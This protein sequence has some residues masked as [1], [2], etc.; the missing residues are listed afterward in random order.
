MNGK[1]SPQRR[2]PGL[3]W[4]SIVVE[5]RPARYGVGGL[6]PCVLFLHGWGIGGRP[7]ARPLEQLVRR[8]IR[9][10]T[11]ALPGFGGTAGLP[12][13]HRTLAGYAR[14]IGHF[15]DAVGLPLPVTVVGH[16]FGGGVAIKAAHD[17]PELAERLV[18]VNSI[19]GSAWT[20]G[21]G[22]VRALRERPLWD[23][24]LHLQADLLPRRQVTRVL[25]VILREAVPNMLRHPAGVWEAAHLARAA[26]LAR[27]LTALAERRLPIFVVWS[28]RD[29]VIPEST[30]MSLRTALGDPHAIT[31]PGGH[32]WL[33]YDPHAFG[34]LITNVI[35][36]PVIGPDS[37]IDR[38][39]AAN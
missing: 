38:P 22:A 39:T 2:F 32:T 11:P 3:R 26:D 36:E 10:Y 15:A 31:V 24:G 13:E 30:S 37:D 33:M 21:R 28:T 18:L 23:W 8:G 5:G 16:S 29:T 35:R 34:E 4:R 19:G 14:W 9:V 17:L 20:D 7:Y 6:G 27:E 12:V 25:P 1:P